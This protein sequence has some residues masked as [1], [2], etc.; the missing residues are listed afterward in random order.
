MD[1]GAILLLLTM[2]LVTVGFILKPFRDSGPV[3]WEEDLELSELLSERER[4]L[5]ALAELDFDNEL[6]KVPEEI[7]EPQRAHLLKFG[8]KVLKTLEEKYP[9][10]TGSDAIEAQIAARRE[11]VK[12]R[13]DADD[14]LEQMISQRREAGRSGEAPAAAG[15]RAKF[16]SQCGEKVEADDR[17]CIKCGSKL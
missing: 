2:V 6:G 16:C 1:I 13:T 10:Q 7:Y 5:E 17:F 11:Q 12:Q 15:G 8:A 14:P 4:V 3:V 9:E